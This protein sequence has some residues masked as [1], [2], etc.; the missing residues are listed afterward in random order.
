[1]V[2]VGDAYISTFWCIIACQSNTL[3][4][5]R[6]DIN[7][8]AR[9]GAIN[10]AAIA[11]FIILHSFNFFPNPGNPGKYNITRKNTSNP[12][13]AGRFFFNEKKHLEVSFK[14]KIGEEHFYSDA[15]KECYLF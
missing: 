3:I 8:N 2:L 13:V 6:F 5:R 14:Q 10:N 1:M 12:A 9:I 7:S 4:V 11:D 15:R